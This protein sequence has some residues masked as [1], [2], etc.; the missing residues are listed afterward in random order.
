MLYRCTYPWL[1][2]KARVDEKS[3]PVLPPVH[4]GQGECVIASN[5]ADFPRFTLMADMVGEDC[6]LIEL[7]GPAVKGPERERLLLGEN[8]EF[9]CE[10]DRLH[11]PEWRQDHDSSASPTPPNEQP[12]N[13][14]VDN[15]LSR[16]QEFE[17]FHN[18]IHNFDDAVEA[19]GASADDPRKGERRRYAPRTV[20]WDAI[21]DRFIAFKDEDPARLDLIVKHA[22]R[23]QRSLR[24]IRQGPKRI[25]QRIHEQAPLDRIQ[26]LDTHCLLDYARRPGRNAPEKAGGRQ[27]LLSVQRRESFNTLE[28]R[29]VVDFCRRSMALCRSYID[30]HKQRYRDQRKHVDLSKSPRFQSVLKYQQFLMAYL[31]DVTWQDVMPLA[32]PCR[33]P[34]YVLSEN[35]LYVEVW[36][37]YLEILKNADLRECIWRWPRRIWA[38]LLRILLAEVLHDVF[39]SKVGIETLPIAKRPVHVTKALQGASLLSKKT[40]PGG[41]WIEQDQ[42]KGCFSVVDKSEIFD[43]FRDAVDV[44]FCNADFYLVWMP[45]DDTQPIKLVPVWGMVG[46][47]RW[48]NSQAA[49][50]MILEWCGSLEESMQAW[51][52]PEGIRLAGA[53]LVH[54]NWTGCEAQE[55]DVGSKEMPLWFIQ[56]HSQGEWKK[57]DL[58]KLVAPIRRLL[59]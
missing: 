34:N 56:I 35:P 47:L 39:K 17:E 10:Y 32:E 13:T 1:A 55:L 12:Y 50:D 43:F 45:D 27:R 51:R 15:L 58:E 44:A 14:F 18:N 57:T 8:K 24:D 38:D 52:L 6:Y 4:G 29:V 31:A 9:I 53:A 21:L 42:R 36:K 22:R 49:E 40:F 20:T 23:M 37:S 3:P 30:Q 19:V 48:G 2:L 41:W 54:A 59:Q 26:E 28:N 7:P 33:M 25:L 11:S 46:D 16:V 5:P